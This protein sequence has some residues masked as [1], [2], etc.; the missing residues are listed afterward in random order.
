MM[1]YHSSHTKD[2]QASAALHSTITG[3]L[4]SVHGVLHESRAALA[5]L[6]CARWG[7]A[8]PPNDEQLKR[9]LEALVASG[10]TLWWINYIGAVASFISACYPAGIVPGTEKR[11]S[12]RTS[13]TRDAKGRSQLDLR[14]H[15]DSSQDVNALAKDAKSIEKVGKPKRWI[16]GKDGVGHK[17]TAEIV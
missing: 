14:I 15:I 4:A 13:W 8:V 16:G 12:F 1:F 10:M 2:I 5:L 17:V 11:L 9:N 3:I 6:L 7:A